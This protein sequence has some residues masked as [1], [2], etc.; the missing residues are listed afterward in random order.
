MFLLV[1][2][3]AK[4]QSQIDFFTSLN[5][6][7]LL[8]HKAISALLKYKEQIQLQNDKRDLLTI[9]SRSGHNYFHYYATPFPPKCNFDSRHGG[10][11]SCPTVMHQMS[12]MHY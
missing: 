4:P 2:L 10:G 3:T 9:E 6:Y 8:L 1:N 7:K 11:W 5:I 12:L